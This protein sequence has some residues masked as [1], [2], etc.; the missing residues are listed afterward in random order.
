M[1]PT[2]GAMAGGGGQEVT[3]EIKPV[4]FLQLTFSLYLRVNRKGIACSL[5]VQTKSKDLEQR[6]VK[7][8]QVST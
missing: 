2:S 6:S 4:P 3:E 1:P 5:D 7:W 8:S